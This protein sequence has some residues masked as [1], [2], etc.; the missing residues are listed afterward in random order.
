[1]TPPSGRRRRPE[2]WIWRKK[3]SIGSAAQAISRPRPASAPVL[4]LGALV[5]RDDDSVLEPAAARRPRRLGGRRV[6]FD[7]V[8]RLAVDGHFIAGLA[9]ARAGDLGLVIA[10]DEGRCRR[11]PG[12][13]E[14]PREEGRRG[15][16]ACWPATASAQA[17]CQSSGRVRPLA[18][19]RL[20]RAGQ[21]IRNAS[22]ARSAAIG[23]ERRE[24][25]RRTER[26]AVGGFGGSAAGGLAPRPAGGWAA[27]SAAVAAAA[28][29]GN[30]APAPGAKR[31]PGAQA[32]R[33][34]G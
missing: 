19:V 27:A 15:R 8:G 20:T 14:M 11:R 32:A 25:A 6:D 7:E 5:I 4:D 33:A 31:L 24:P 30:A 17:G 3:R 21:L 29:L 12:R 28:K 13:L 22:S 16:G 23:V 9:S 10:G 34:G 2:P 18:S 1:M 26:G